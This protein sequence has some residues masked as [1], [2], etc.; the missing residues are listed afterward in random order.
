[1]LYL[2]MFGLILDPLIIVLTESQLRM[3]PII[4]TYIFFQKT[5]HHLIKYGINPSIGM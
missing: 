5:D 4:A 2:G 1:M 3:I